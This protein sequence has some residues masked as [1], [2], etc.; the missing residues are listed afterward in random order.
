MAVCGAAFVKR[1]SDFGR[2]VFAENDVGMVGA[3]DMGRGEAREM[4]AA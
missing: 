4:A 2:A 1:R 3:A